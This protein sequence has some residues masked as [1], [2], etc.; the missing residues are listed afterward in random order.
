MHAPTSLIYIMYKCVKLVAPS[1]FI[2]HDT[3]CSVS[4]QSAIH[5]PPR[6]SA[7]HGVF[8]RELNEMHPKPHSSTLQKVYCEGA[9]RETH[10]HRSALGKIH[11]MGCTHHP[12]TLQY[13][14]YNVSE[15]RGMHLPFSELSTIQHLEYSTLCRGCKIAKY[16][17]KC[18]AALI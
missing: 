18:G 10:S 8:V 7:L 2:L 15:R 17:A 3:Q 11:Y 6:Y 4:E 14:V 13:T 9:E 1:P 16:S 12:F 5:T